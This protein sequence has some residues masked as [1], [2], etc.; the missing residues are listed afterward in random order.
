[1]YSARL[2]LYVCRSTSLNFADRQAL[3]QTIF[4]LVRA[5]N[6]FVQAWHWRMRSRIWLDASSAITLSA[7]A[8]LTAVCVV[9]FGWPAFQSQLPFGCSTVTT[10]SSERCAF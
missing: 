9:R 10:W 8:G 5:K 1:M 7:E 6:Q 2:C 3:L 4:L